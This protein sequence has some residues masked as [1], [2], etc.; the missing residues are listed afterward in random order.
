MWSFWLVK[1]GR[2]FGKT[3]TGAEWV[4]G[5]VESN[6]CGRMAFV[7]KD[8]GE[9]RD[10]MV[11][12]DSGIL[13]ISPPWF[14]P[15][16]ETTK[17]R[18]TWP[19]GAIATIYSSEDP[20]ELRGPQFDGAWV[21]ELFK[22]RTQ[23]DVWDQLMFGLRLGDNPQVCI[24]STPRPTKLM[25]MIL[26]DPATVVTGGSTYDNLKNLSPIYQNI[27]RRFEGTRLG[28]QELNAEILDDTPGALWNY[29]QLDRLRIAS[30][31]CELI[32]IGVAIDPAVTS[33]EDSA[34]T[35]M[36]VGGLGVDGHGY[37]LADI[38][39]SATPD[40]WARHAI[41]H[42]ETYHG[43]RIIAEVNNGGDL[44][45]AVLRH[46]DRTVPYRAVHASRGKRT[47]AEPISAL[48]EQNLIHHVGSFP[49]LEDQMC[50]Y[51]PL[52]PGVSPDRMDALV[53]LFTDLFQ[54]GAI[55]MSEAEF[56]EQKLTSY[57]FPSNTTVAVV[58]DDDTAELVSARGW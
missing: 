36:I 13:S 24:T 26:K 9:A 42:L 20:E 22:M 25:M 51:D 16:Y 21:D 45:E 54:R 41:S 33:N 17:K 5:K 49:E 48:Y 6:Q 8:P 57:N 31:P 28:R 2:G 3:R 32:R 18:L 39:I 38:T 50:T 29:K 12:G 43:D 46:V 14:M 34:E 23:Q 4:R 35:G 56:G 1:A 58:D 55:D 10:V 37:V 19:N 52:A 11:E 44:V 53:W 15:K 7:A 27:I 47:R 30:V 40:A